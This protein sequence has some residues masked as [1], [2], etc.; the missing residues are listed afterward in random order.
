MTKDKI[1]NST[2]I[3]LSVLKTGKVSHLGLLNTVQTIPCPDHAQDKKNLK[4]L[5]HVG[6]HPLLLDPVYDKGQNSQ[7]LLM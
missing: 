2:N 4:Y 3:I 6:Q 5:P 1:H 7:F